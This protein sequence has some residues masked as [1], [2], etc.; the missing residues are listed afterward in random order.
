MQESFKNRVS[1]FW[2]NFS[3]KESE[4]RKMMDAKTEG[5]KLIAFVDE[6]LQTAFHKVYFE[7]GINEDGKYE[8]ILTPEGDRTKLIQIHYWLQYAPEH[9]AEKW[10]FY[11]TKPGKADVG[12][13]LEMFGI[14]LEAKDIQVYAEPDEERKKIDIQIYA[15]KLMKLDENQRYS[16]FFIELDQFIS[17]I[18]TME[19]IGFVDFVEDEPEDEQHVPLEKMKSYIDYVINEN[20]WS[21][22]GNPCEEYS[23]YNM[24]PVQ[25]EN[26]ELRKDIV[27]GYTSCIPLLNVYYAGENELFDSFAEDGVFFGFIYYENSNVPR[28][29]TVAFRTNIEEKISDKSIDTGIAHPIGGATGYKYSYIDFVVFDFESFMSIAKEALTGND[30]AEAGFAFFKASEDATSLI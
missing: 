15:P 13:S 22:P 4:V 18:Y 25:T 6:I 24:K 12:F 5:E 21:K 29:N 26:W 16:I 14:S 7:M 17:E 8:L 27:A 28:E 20:D 11:S 2:N 23:A 30:F 19:Y 1:E 10:N 3:E 9:L